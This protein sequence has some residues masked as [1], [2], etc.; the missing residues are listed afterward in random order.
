VLDAELPDLP[1]DTRGVGPAISTHSAC[2]LCLV[3][4]TGSCTLVTAE[5]PL[6]PHPLLPSLPHVAERMANALSQVIRHGSS[7]VAA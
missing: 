2:R 7:L 1:V 5:R 6:A 4:E 3:E